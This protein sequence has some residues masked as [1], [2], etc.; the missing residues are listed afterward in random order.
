MAHSVRGTGSYAMCFSEN[1]AMSK[2]RLVPTNQLNPQ[3]TSRLF[4]IALQATV[5]NTDPS[6]TGVDGTEQEHKRQS[7]THNSQYRSVHLTPQQWQLLTDYH[8]HELFI[9]TRSWG[10]CLAIFGIGITLFGLGSPAWKWIGDAR[11][12][13][14]MGLWALCFPNAS[15]LSLVY[16]LQDEWKIHTCIVCLLGCACLFGLLGL[17]LAITGACRSALVI[18]MYY[19]H[20]AGECFL[21]SGVA[22]ISSMILYPLSATACIRNLIEHDVLQIS[23]SENID[24]KVQH[25]FAYNYY[26][27]WS[28]SLFFVISF[29]CMN[30]DLLIQSLVRLLPSFS[31]VRQYVNNCRG[32]GKSRAI[33]QTQRQLHQSDSELIN[34]YP[35]SYNC[36]KTND[37]KHLPF[38]QVATQV[39]LITLKGCDEETSATVKYQRTNTFSDDEGEW[40]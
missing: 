4:Q 1:S 19:Y 28:A 26:L 20:S 14:E 11:R 27:T 6:R 30:L 21:V 2:V 40:V 32:G 7:S 13:Y 17:G 29:V 35:G 37:L 34:L 39:P 36:D 16:Y 10:F 38:D 12:P 22:I 18:R 33:D 5:A 8:E 24:G 25:R 3:N 31:T 9:R 15:C 23:A